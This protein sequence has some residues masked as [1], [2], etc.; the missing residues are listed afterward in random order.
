MAEISVS[1]TVSMEEKTNRQSRKEARNKA[2][3]DE[4]TNLY[5]KKSLRLEVVI[6]R[7][8]ERFFLSEGTILAI[9]FEW[10]HYKKNDESQHGTTL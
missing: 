6:T 3:R 5:D 2:I 7:L 9:V 1:L 8:S 4:F 10:G